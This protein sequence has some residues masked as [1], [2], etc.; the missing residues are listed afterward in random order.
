MLYLIILCLHYPEKKLLKTLWEY[1]KMLLT[2][3]FTFSL[4]VFINPLK[5][6]QN[7]KEVGHNL[8]KSQINLGHTI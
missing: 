1:E 4:N 5:R 8:Y 2:S 6:D 7:P 3:T